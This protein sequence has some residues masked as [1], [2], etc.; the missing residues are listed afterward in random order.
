MRMQAHRAQQPGN[1][2]V[3]SVAQF[4]A[5]PR[6]VAHGVEELGV[7]LG[8]EVVIHRP[9]MARAFASDSSSGTPCT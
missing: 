7:R 4:P 1:L 6:V 3:K 9:R 2:V 8:M 5:D